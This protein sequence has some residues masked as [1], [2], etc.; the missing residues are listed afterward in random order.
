M[1]HF[2]NKDKV[3]REVLLYVNDEVIDSLGESYGIGVNDFIESVKKGADWATH[4]GFCQKALQACEAWRDRDFEY[5]PYVSY[6]AFFVLA[7][8]TETN[9]APHSYYPG[10]WKRLG[11]SQ[12]IGTPPSF[13]HM[14]TLW[15]DLEKWSREDM[16]EE[17]GRFVARIRGG[18][19][20]VGLPRSQTVLSEN[21]R[22]HLIRLFDEAGLDPTDV[23]SPEVIP[24]I[25]MRYGQGILENR[26]LKLLDSTQAEDTVLRKALAEVVLDEIE[27]WDGTVEEHVFTDD[28][29]RL[30]VHTGLRLCVNLDL[31]AAS[32]NVYVRFKTNKM[33]PEDGLCFK[34][35]HVDSVWFCREVH[36]GWSTP[37]MN[38]SSEPLG[39]LDGAALNWND[40]VKFVDS[41]NNWR[42]TLR[43]AKIR[44]FRLRI[45]GLPDWVETQKLE[46]GIEFLVACS[47]EYKD[48]VKE[49][50]NNN[51]SCFVHRDVSGLP[52]EWFLYYGK[53]ASKSCPG[54]DILSLSTTARLILTEGIKS[55][56][57][58]VYFR[59][60]PPKV[61][62][63]NGYGLEKVTINGEQLKRPDVHIPVWVLPDDLSVD[64][65]LRIEIDL[66]EH[67]LSKMIRLEEFDLPLSFDKTPC[68]DS[69]GEI[70]AS[71]ISVRASGTVVYSEKEIT[72]YPDFT[73]THLSDRIIFLGEIPGEIADW[74]REPIPSSWHPVWAVVKKARKQW[75]VYFCGKPE[76]LKRDCTNSKPVGKRS[77]I[78][79]WKEALWIRRKRV[80]PPQI[81]NVRL[82][83]ENYMRIAR[84]V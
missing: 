33:F 82:I 48:K 71:G 62:V 45:N 58:N 22:K 29:P 35:K 21:E 17:L 4:T 38:I 7:A 63:E 53:N 37:L 51:C 1:K 23:P 9:Y 50:G 74:P 76:H 83:W 73:P 81:R 78:K 31:L 80:V 59:F 18:Y 54:I 19:M 67:R 39:K 13:D 27:E 52:S 68:R 15:D 30:Q 75:D 55:G 61:M 44:L 26:T 16:H 49:W 3:G 47:L 43:G 2:F 79:R 69:K 5:P 6:L 24:K 60:A 70:C 40:G 72:S 46:R 56:R 32:A 20:N 10:F 34:E 64:Q 57:G 42:A 12:D 11:E 84:N 77:R 65:P 66:G 14:I 41:E 8:V 28:R 25:L 36:Q